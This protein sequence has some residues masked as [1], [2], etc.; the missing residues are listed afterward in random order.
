MVVHRRG[1][2]GI[3]L[4]VGAAALVPAAGAQAAVV[5]NTNNG[6]Q[7]S[8]AQAIA[9]TNASPGDDVITFAS[10]VT[11]T[12]TIGSTLDIT[13]ELSIQGPGANLLAVSGGNANRVI[14]INVATPGQDVTISGLTI[15]DGRFASAAGINNVDSDF[16][17][18]D[19]IVTGNHLTGAGAAGGIYHHGSDPS[20]GFNSTILRSTISGN[21]AGLGGGITVRRGINIIDSTISG[22]SASQRGGGIE[23]RDTYGTGYAYVYSSTVAGNTAS[24]EGGGIYAPPSGGTRGFL[25]NSVVADNVAPAG[26]DLRNAFTTDFAL[27][28]NVSGATLTSLSGTPPPFTGDPALGPL[29]SNGGPTPTQKPALTSLLVDKGRTTLP[30]DQRGLPRAFDVPSLA[31]AGNGA[32]LGAVELQAS[33]F[34]VAAAKPK[35]KAKKKKKGKGKAAAEPAAKKKKKKKCKKKRKK[36]K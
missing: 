31:N 6:G 3:G 34:L 36:K 26:P 14:Y 27:V 9:D 11:G 4:T 20:N 1:I 17:L 2:A 19:S 22:N 29:A 10:G 5:L 7:D 8:L 21:S 32:D 33:D 13:D 35:C 16:T 18:S 23:V 12:I 15:R 25:S 30:I 24:I 28:E